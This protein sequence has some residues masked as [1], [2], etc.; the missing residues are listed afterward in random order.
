[1]AKRDKKTKMVMDR[2]FLIVSAALLIFITAIS[3]YSIAFLS[4]HLLT[5][6]TFSNNKN[7]GV[8][9][10][11]FSGYEEITGTPLEG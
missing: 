9:E 6:L 2:W 10:F 5:G 8:I 4:R 3:I 1:M 11:D 7:E